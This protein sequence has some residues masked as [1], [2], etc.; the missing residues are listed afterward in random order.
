MRKLTAI[1]LTVL[2][3]FN[4]IG[5]RLVFYYAL[6]QADQTV[7][8]RL[9]RNDYNES[10]LVAITIP[11]SMPYQHSSAGFER[12]DGE[13]TLHGKIYRFVK[14][15]YGD[16]KITFLC[17]PD[18]HKTRLENAKSNIAGVDIPATGSRQQNN[19]KISLGK[20]LN[21]EYHSNQATYP[22]G[23]CTGVYTLR[24]QSGYFTV[25]SAY[26]FSPEQPPEQA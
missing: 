25:S 13:I 11:I 16:N 22:I 24:F 21:S 9:D 23:T 12:C 8:Q 20:L 6:R 7:E 18:Q 19:S 14:R 3:L 26:H 1:F 17:L 4:L 15:E 5:Y 10:E 2:F